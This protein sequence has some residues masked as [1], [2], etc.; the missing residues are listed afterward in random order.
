LPSSHT[1]GRLT[2]P[3]GPLGFFPG[4]PHRQKASPA[5][6]PMKKGDFSEKWAIIAVFKESA[7]LVMLFLQAA[8]RFAPIG[9]KSG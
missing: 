7:D 1:S 2:M 3:E 5:K 6:C 4:Y 8:L 9:R